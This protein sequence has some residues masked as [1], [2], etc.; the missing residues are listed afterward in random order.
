MTWVMI[1]AMIWAMGTMVVTM[2]AM[3]LAKGM[4]GTP[5]GRGGAAPGGG[6]GSGGGSGNN[7]S[8]GGCMLQGSLLFIAKI[9]LCGIFMMWG[10]N[11]R[12]HT[13]PHTLVMLEVCR[14]TFGW[15]RKLSSKIVVCKWSNPKINYIVCDTQ[16]L[17][18]DMCLCSSFFPFQN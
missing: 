16:T 15:G 2:P 6:R 3:T 9:F 17:I 1:R 5:V 4:A 13:S 14:R 18:C 7:G 8:N 11:W 10:G 12:G